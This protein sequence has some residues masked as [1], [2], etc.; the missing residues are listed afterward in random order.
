MAAGIDNAD[1]A[2]LFELFG[3]FNGGVDENVAAFLG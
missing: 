3:L 1:A 2:D